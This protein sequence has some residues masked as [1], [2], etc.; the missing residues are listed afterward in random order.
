MESSK[1]INFTPSE[2][3]NQ[4]KEY[5]LIF[6]PDLHLKDYNPKN[7]RDIHKEYITYLKRINEIV[8]QNKIDIVIFLGDI[9]DR[10]FVKPRNTKIKMDIINHLRELSTLSDTY[11]L[12]GNHEKHNITEHNPWFH[13]TSIESEVLK[14]ELSRYP[15]VF[16]NTLPILKAVDSIAIHDVKIDMVH[17]SDIKQYYKRQRD[18]NYVTQ[19]GCYHDFLITDTIK[20]R[21][22]EKNNFNIDTHIGDR[23]IDVTSTDIFDNYQHVVIGD[24]HLPLG[25]VYVGDT[26]VD[27][28]GTIG[29]NNTLENHDEVFLPLFTIKPGE[30]IKERVRF[31]LI[32]FEESFLMNVV[33]LEKKNR[34]NKKKLKDTLTHVDKVLEIDELL[35]SIVETKTDM[36]IRESVFNQEQKYRSLSHTVLEHIKYD[37]LRKDLENLYDE[38]ENETDDQ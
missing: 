1:I 25:E 33:Q 15:F 9:F 13:L 31:K 35:D 14:E 22:I 12:M 16:E 17:F 18:E 23:Y 21:F 8:L 37:I 4:C 26:L 24:I 3:Y 2:I 5:K 6:I 11:T 38:K 32:P 28:P 30:V 10:D 19:I 7:R 34:I 27:G 36:K 29:R 20:K